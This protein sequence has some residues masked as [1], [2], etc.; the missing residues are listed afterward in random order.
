M[1]V[2]VLLIPS[3]YFTKASAQGGHEGHM[4]HGDHGDHADHG[5]HQALSDDEIKKRMM[6]WIPGA[7]AK[8][9]STIDG[10]LSFINQDGKKVK[11]KE[12]F[13]RPVFVAFIFTSCPHI[14]PTINQNMAA[15]AKEARKKYGDKF[16]LLTISFDTIRDD[17]KGIKAYSQNFTTEPKFWT[18][19]LAE[20]ESVD[21]L[22]AAFGFSFLPSEQDIWSHITMVTVVDKGGVIT[23]QIYGT[24][25]DSQ[26]F[27]DAL[28]AMLGKK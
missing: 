1:I 16:R 28:G 23:K 11:L 14:C 7:D 25:V 10:N 5:G 8:I 22:T 19:G 9:G 2:T 4:A 17:I 15:A 13:D 18:F 24:K 21:K 20:K 6:K 3:T 26:E 12:F 27:S